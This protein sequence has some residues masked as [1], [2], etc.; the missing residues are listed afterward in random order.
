MVVLF[1]LSRFDL[2]SRKDRS[3]LVVIKKH[4][5]KSFF[6]HCLTQTCK[7]VRERFLKIKSQPNY[8]L[9]ETLISTI[10]KIVIRDVVLYVEGKIG[11]AKG[12]V[13]R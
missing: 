13:G 12:V 11:V 8:E 7:T 3:S 6:L 2:K 5:K 4:Q 9:M 1:E 10:Q